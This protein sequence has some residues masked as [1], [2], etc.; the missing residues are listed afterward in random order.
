MYVCLTEPLKELN[1]SAFENFGVFLGDRL[2]GIEWSGEVT[3]D[4]E[5]SMSKGR[6]L[7]AV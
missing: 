6:M 7:A 4:T 3:L 2:S 5:S 1:I